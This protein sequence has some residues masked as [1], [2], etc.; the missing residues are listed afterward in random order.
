MNMAQA[1]TTHNTLSSRRG[2]LAQ[3]AGVAAGGAALGMALPLPTG[4]E[5]LQR[6]PDPI[7]EAIERHRSAYDAFSSA[8][9]TNSA[10]EQ[11]IPKDKRKSSHDWMGELTT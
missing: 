8:V 7:L 5:P 4:A 3:A 2:F 9:S 10:L 1:E 6:V 11:V